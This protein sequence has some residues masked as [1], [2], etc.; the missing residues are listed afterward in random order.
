MINVNKINQNND[1]NVGKPKI[2]RE[3]SSIKMNAVY[4]GTGDM[5]YLIPAHHHELLPS[6]RIT[7][8]VDIGLQFNPFVSNLFHEINGEI[9]CHFVPFRLLWDEWE[10]FIIGGIDGQD[11]TEHPTMSLKELWEATS[12]TVADR[13]LIHTL[14]DYFHMPINWDFASEDEDA[15]KPSAFLWWAYN[16]IY[17]DHIRIID[18][19]TT[20]IDQDNNELLRGNWDWDYFTRSRVYQQRGLTPTVPVSDELEQLAHTLES[21]LSIDAA[22]AV[23]YDSNVSPVQLGTTNSTLTSNATDTDGI[24]TALEKQ[25]ITDISGIADH[26]LDQLGM[27]LN[28]F[29]IALGIMRVQINNAKIQPKYI[30]QL[31]ARFGIYPEDARLQRPEYVGSKYFPVTTETVTQTSYGDTDSGQTPQGNITGQAWGGNN[32]GSL[33][34]S[35]EAKEHGLLFT[36]FIIRPKGVYEGGLQKRDVRKTRFDYATPELSNLPDVE[37]Y[38]R[39][40]MYTGD[41][42]TSDD[43]LFGWQGIYEE[44]RTL[45]NQVCGLLRP[46]EENGLHSMT[47]ARYWD[48]TGEDYP[49][50]NKE[51]VGCDPDQDRILQYV[52]EPAFM[53]FIRNQI[54]T[55]LP[56][57]L[58]SEPGELSFL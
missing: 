14:A 10:T 41:D 13:T 9:L 31:Q 17:N 18:F 39:E 6:Q 52:D 48:P 30:E 43:V 26:E 8:N 44:Y 51:F 3:Y 57:P 47:L 27:N 4:S 46:S 35:Y 42:G 16:R 56:L 54:F 24:Q 49:S 37:V 1:Y 5:G 15:T 38:R 50:L 7:L 2:D 29:L 53:F 40:L 25:K 20:E 55:A 21:D 28:D 36:Q 32:K 22:D 33:S 45:M 23:E 12:E 11:A 34:F 58:Q 19:E